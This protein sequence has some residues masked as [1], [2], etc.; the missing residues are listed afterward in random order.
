[1]PAADPRATSLILTHKNPGQKA[2]YWLEMICEKD[3][4]GC[5]GAYV[6]V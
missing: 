1:M 6:A 3:F 5:D 4:S 2:R